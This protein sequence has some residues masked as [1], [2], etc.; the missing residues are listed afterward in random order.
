[1]Q[2]KKIIFFLFD[3]FATFMVLILSNYLNMQLNKAY[4]FMVCVRVSH[5][6]TCLLL[7]VGSDCFCV[8]FLF[9][10]RQKGKADRE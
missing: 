1:M 10:F 6:L 4:V 7:L 3:S 5:V 2:K 9:I 8:F